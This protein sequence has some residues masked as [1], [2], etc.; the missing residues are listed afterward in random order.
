MGD[1]ARH[2][3]KVMYMLK[4]G[5]VLYGGFSTVETTRVSTP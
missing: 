5:G 4:P 2:Y 3:W 1:E